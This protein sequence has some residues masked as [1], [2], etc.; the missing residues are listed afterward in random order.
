[1]SSGVDVDASELRRELK[2]I[3]RRVEDFSPITPVLAEILVSYVNDRWDSAGDGEWPGLAASTLRKRRKRG[4]GA[5]ILK[6]TG[7]AAASVRGESDAT[8]ASAVTDTA[9]MV[10]HVS[11]APRSVIPLRNPFDVFDAAAPEL[12]ETIAAWVA[13]GET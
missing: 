10:Y 6:D 3:D 12:E 9:Y 13:T 7:R 11:D 5:Q 8:S 4:L 2:N 1:M